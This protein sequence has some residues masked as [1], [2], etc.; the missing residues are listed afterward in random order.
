MHEVMIDATAAERF[1]PYALYS[2]HC[3]AVQN[4]DFTS[5]WL[6]HLGA[7]VNLKPLLLEESQRKFVEFAVK[8]HYPRMIKDMIGMIN[9]KTPASEGKRWV[10][11]KL[12]NLEITEKLQQ[13]L[14]DI[15]HNLA[16]GI[17]MD[18][19]NI[20]RKVKD[21]FSSIRQNPQTFVKDYE[22]LENALKL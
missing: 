13:E 17:S 1:G 14:D 12:G 20:K 3:D 21:P 19:K 4:G 8:T 5:A 16:R 9:H 15:F 6:Y 2:F 22:K 18:R 7:L 11:K 10:S